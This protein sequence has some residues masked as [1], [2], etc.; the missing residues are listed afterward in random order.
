MS[1]SYSNLGSMLTR[2]LLHYQGK[3]LS[4]FVRFFFNM[5]WFSELAFNR[6]LIMHTLKSSRLDNSC[7]KK[8]IRFAQCFNNLESSGCYSCVSFSLW[9][10]IYLEG[11]VEPC[12]CW[13]FWVL[14][15][16]SSG[17]GKVW[18]QSAKKC[19]FDSQG[20]RNCLCQACCRS[21]SADSSMRY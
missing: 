16:R 15:T 12:L 6:T 3:V 11:W 2:K 13:N 4:A 14:Y 9:Q 1:D 18:H 10:R 8:S 5:N 21:K 20:K 7:R 17:S 19:A